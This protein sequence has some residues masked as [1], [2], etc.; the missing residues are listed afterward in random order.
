MIILAETFKFTFICSKINVFL[1]KYFVITLYRPRLFYFLNKLNYS[2]KFFKCLP[3]H[4]TYIQ[5]LFTMKMRGLGEVFLL[6]GNWNRQSSSASLC[7]SAPLSSWH[8]HNYSKLQS[9]Y[10]P[11]WLPGHSSSQ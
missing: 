5:W 3:T 6:R 9:A 2:N 8:Q 11:W 4:I 7:A 1:N 10:G